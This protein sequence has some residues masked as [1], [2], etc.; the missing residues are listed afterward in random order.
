MFPV[1]G[2]VRLRKGWSSIGI[3]IACMGVIFWFSAL[4]SSIYWP[5]R[6][7]GKY[8]ASG[9]DRPVL[10]YYLK[11]KNKGLISNNED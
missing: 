11:Q 6:L 3:T 2:L 1:R 7:W 5:I 8:W 9:V 4:N 10:P